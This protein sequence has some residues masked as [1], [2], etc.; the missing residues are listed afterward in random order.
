MP[1]AGHL[2]LISRRRFIIVSVHSTG[3]TELEHTLPHRHHSNDYKAYIYE[4]VNDGTVW[5]A[6]TSAQHLIKY[7]MVNQEAVGLWW[8]DPFW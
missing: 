2:L 8:A 5:M 1:I 6:K 7:T 4:E 3:S